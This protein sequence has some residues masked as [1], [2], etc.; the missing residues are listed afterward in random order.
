MTDSQ[1]FCPASISQGTISGR[2]ITIVKMLEK[3]LLG[4]R[5]AKENREQ[6]KVL[7]LPAHI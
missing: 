4:T 1:S 2:K 3:D 7:S 6:I 5:E